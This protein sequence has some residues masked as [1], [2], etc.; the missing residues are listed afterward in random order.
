VVDAALGQR[1]G[2]HR[3]DLGVALGA[4]TSISSTPACRIALAARPAVRRVTAPS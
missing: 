3:D 4:G 2:G 1:G